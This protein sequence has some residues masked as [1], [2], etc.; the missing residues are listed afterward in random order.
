MSSNMDQQRLNQLQDL[1]RADI[2]AGLYHGAVIKVARGGKVALEAAIGAADAAQAQ[3]LSLS[4]VFSIFSVTKAFTNV[5]VLQAIEQGRFALTTPISDLIPEFK[6]HG[7]EKVQMWHLL[8]HQA[9]FPI[10]FEVRPGWYINDFAEVSAIVVEDVKPVDEPCAKVSYSPLVNH[11]LMAEALL[12]TDPRQAR[13]PRSWCRR[14]SS[15]R[16]ACAIPRWGCVPISSPARW[17]RIS[18]ATIPS[19]T[20]A[21]TW[22]GPNGAFEDETRG[23]ALGGHRLDDAGHVPLRRNAS[24]RRH[25]G[26]RAPAFTRDDRDG[27]PQLDGRE[28]QRALCPA[29]PGRRAGAGAGVHRTGIS[30]CGARRCAPPSSARWPRP[31]PSA[32]TAPAPRCSGSTRN[33][34]SLLSVSLPA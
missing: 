24:P 6:G 3:P 31:A 23:N 4:S 17:C 27:G 33:A 21:A 7:R 1:I 12:R 14:R 9:G 29:R 20:R 30:R 11:V 13:L 22:P 16:W 32:T 26:R 2:A 19:G 18:A 10:L 15:I 25:A 5:L 34:T 28:D 8:S